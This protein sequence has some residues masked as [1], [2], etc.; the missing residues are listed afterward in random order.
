MLLDFHTQPFLTKVGAMLSIAIV[1]CGVC[2]I[3][4]STLFILSDDVP[5]FFPLNHPQGTYTVTF[6]CPDGQNTDERQPGNGDRYCIEY[7]GPG[8]FVGVNENGKGRFL[9]ITVGRSKVDLQPFIDKRVR[10]LK[11]DFNSR[12]EQC[13]RD[14]CTGIGGPMAV[15]DI[16]GI[17]TVR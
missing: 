2:I 14:N 7:R 3:A 12:S 16:D 4:L 11:G 9:R 13:I 6:G 5:D 17:E 10:I 1:V 8:I 15:L